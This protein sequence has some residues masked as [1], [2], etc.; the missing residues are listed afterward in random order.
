[1]ERTKKGKDRKKRTKIE[2]ENKKR[3]EKKEKEMK[4]EEKGKLGFYESPDKENVEE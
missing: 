2:K 3:D 4:G 1:M